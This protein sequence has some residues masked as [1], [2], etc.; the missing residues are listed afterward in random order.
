MQSFQDYV[1]KERERLNS[2]REAIVAKRKELDT[3]LAAIDREFKAVQA[4]E[5]AKAGK[6]AR[7]SSSRK[8]GSRKGSKRDAIIAVLEGSP[9]GLTRAEI[10]EQMGLK[11]N[12]TGEMSVSN[13]LTALTKGNQVARKDKK[14]VSA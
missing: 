14:Y 13:A 7:A 5:A 2:E 10:L 3:Q 1:T 6:P 8:T 11:G 9:D 4:Y 12:K